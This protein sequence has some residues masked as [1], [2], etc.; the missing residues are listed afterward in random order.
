LQK[1]SAAAA[2]HKNTKKLP[3]T[4]ISDTELK[5]AQNAGK[6]IGVNCNA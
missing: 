4:K 2:S 6:I 1:P 5:K 3:F